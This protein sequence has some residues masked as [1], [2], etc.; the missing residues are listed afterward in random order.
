MK[1]LKSFLLTGAGFVILVGGLVISGLQPHEVHSKAVQDVNLVNTAGNPVP[2]TDVDTVLPSQMVVLWSANIGVDPCPEPFS[3]KFLQ[4]FPNGTRA[5][6]P[7][8]VPSGKVLVVT[9]VFWRIEFADPNA[10][11]GGNLSIQ[12]GNISDFNSETVFASETLAGS[13]GSAA[14][15]TGISPGIVVK[16]GVNLCRSTNTRAA[17]VHGYLAPD[18]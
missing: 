13:N 16:S 2:V 10:S 7:F 14:A 1:T 15:N 18:I 17:L 12:T 5:S 9:N 8:T 6:S 11:V 4:I 3:E